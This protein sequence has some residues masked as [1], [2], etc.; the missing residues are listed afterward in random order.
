MNRINTIRTFAAGFIA[1]AAALA[2]AA[3]TT[4]LVTVPANTPPADTVY[5]AG[6]FQGWNPG[7]PAHAL[8]RQPDGRWS[9]T[10]DLPDS[11]EIQF[12]FTRGTWARV[13]KGPS[14][15]EIPNR[16]YTPVGTQTV[17]LTVANWADIVPSTVT[18]HVE[19]LTHA[20]F[21]N[22]RRCWVYLPPGYFDS[23]R[24]YPVLYM[25]DGQNLFDQ[26]ASFA[27]EWRVDETCETLIAAGEIEPVIVVGIENG[28]GSRCN[29]YT[30]WFDAGVGCGGAGHAY[31]TAIR[32]IL[33]PEVDLRYRTRPGANYMAGSSLGGLISAYAG[34]AFDAWPRVA[35]VSP[36]YWFSGTQMLTYAQAAGRPPS[37]A[38]FYQDIGTAESGQANVNT[39]RNIAL[40]Q[41]FLE[42]EDFLTVVAQGHG[43][44]EAAWAQRL[45]N[46]LRF[47]IDPPADTCGPADLNEDGVLDLADINAFVQAFI[48]QQPA[49][50]LDG[51]GIY[52]LADISAFVAAFTAGCI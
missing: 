21:L 32:D 23:D 44:N 33:M 13:E 10:L 8:T 25:H 27:G 37:F 12:K 18:G 7:S 26:A 16:R 39:M 5:I 4:F 29:E 17:P 34:Y 6:D 14:G 47:L 35:A 11:V 15:E 51:N 49:A 19:F 46:I 9:I 28:G 52:D 22:G 30:P 20:P 36:S 43:H 41:G 3:T 1:F 38:R 31:L 45:P 42:G 48:N 40:A 50:D 24:H 2:S